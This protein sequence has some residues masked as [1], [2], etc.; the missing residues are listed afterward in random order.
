ME[1]FVMKHMRTRTTAVGVALGVVFLVGTWLQPATATIGT[2][3]HLWKQHVRPRADARYLQNT[4]VYVTPAFSIDGLADLTVTRAC[5]GGTKAIGGGVDFATANANV[6]VISDAPIVNSANL[7]AAA[8]G[9][10][11]AASGW[12][13]TMH[14]NGI[15]AVDG[16]VGVI[17]SR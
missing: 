12:R 17:C 2:P 1:G 16:V 10:N 7:F 15:L 13:V 8:T 3:T 6:Q 5:P 14:N 4:S 9:R 11:P